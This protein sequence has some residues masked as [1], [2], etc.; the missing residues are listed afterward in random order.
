MTTANTLLLSLEA[1]LRTQTFLPAAAQRVAVQPVG[2]AR[3][4]LPAA[5]VYAAIQLQ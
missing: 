3:I 4:C 2:A 1:A 5:Q